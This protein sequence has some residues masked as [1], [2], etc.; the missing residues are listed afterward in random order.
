MN[1]N[2]ELVQKEAMAQTQARWA[3]EPIFN[4]K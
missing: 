2:A 4:K 3:K 1:K